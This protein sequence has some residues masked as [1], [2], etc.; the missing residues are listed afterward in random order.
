MI[1]T[2]L[3]FILNAIFAS[4]ASLGFA[5]VFNVPRKT[6]VYC[7]IGGSITLSLR[8]IFLHYGL[9]IEISAFFAST[10]IGFI[11]LYWSFKNKIPRPTYTVASIIPIIPGTYAIKTMT[12]LISM[13]N[14]GVNNELMFSFMENGLKTV[15]ILGAI[16]FGIALPSIYFLRRNKPIV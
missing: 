15:S 16:S 2:V 8:N 7:A 5:M 6:L 4:I 3:H 13:N 11:S 10:I 14:N 1:E 12:I 9:S